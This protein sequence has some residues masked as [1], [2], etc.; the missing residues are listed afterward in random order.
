MTDP[1][2]PPLL[3]ITRPSVSRIYDWLLG[4]KDNFEP[5]RR[6]AQRISEADPRAPEA[7]RD[8]RAFLR[9]AVRHLAA[10]S[11]I[12]QFLDLGSGL[13]TAE[14]VHQV[15]QSAA[16]GSRVVYV[17]NDAIACAHG[18]A[19]LASPGGSCSFVEADLR[20]PAAVL[21][22]AGK[23]LDFS[24]PV[25]VLLFAVL[26]FVPPEDDP[27]GIVRRFMDAVPPGS[28]LAVSHVTAPPGR[29]AAVREIQEAYALSEPGGVYPRP[30][31]EIA[32][33]FDGLDLVAPGLV[34]IRA[35]RPL[36]E[37]PPDPAEPVFYGGVAAG[38]PPEREP[39][40]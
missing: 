35:W 8:N 7:A 15:A 39:G 11:G 36:E 14:N 21:A 1:E 3:D 37:D 9:R 29:E 18:R 30:L 34:D 17:D 12:R 2:D 20:D 5:D 24:Q 40:E 22:Q 28:C 10:E 25:A 27:F 38:K 32:R 4:G 19:L 26:H 16:P 33:F 23:T 6:I 31:D 13:P